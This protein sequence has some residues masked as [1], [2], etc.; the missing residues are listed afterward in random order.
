MS[1]NNNDINITT[2]NK[3]NNNNKYKCSVLQS[4]TYDI[5]LLKGISEISSILNIFYDTRHEYYD[6]QYKGV[7]THVSHAKAGRHKNVADGQIGG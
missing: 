3:N 6:F 1:N 2:E 7:L 5:L 4:Y